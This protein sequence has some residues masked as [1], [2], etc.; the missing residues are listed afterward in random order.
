MK[1]LQLT[2]YKR[3]KV[4]NLPTPQPAADEVLIAARACGIC[5]S[6]VHGYDGSPPAAE[7]RPW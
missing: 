2:D 4:V 3:L 6:D 7:S 5:G 1:A